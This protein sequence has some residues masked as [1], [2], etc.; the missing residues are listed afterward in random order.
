MILE[1]DPLLSLMKFV[2]SLDCEITDSKILSLKD[3]F[4]NATL[5]NVRD[6]IGIYGEESFPVNIFVVSGGRVRFK[7]LLLCMVSW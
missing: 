2:C 5:K 7:R 3:N 6:I 1:N 4:L